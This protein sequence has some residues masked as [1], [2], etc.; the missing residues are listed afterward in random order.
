[1]EAGEGGAMG[2]GLGE[3]AVGVVGWEAGGVE[4]LG[5]SGVGEGVGRVGEGGIG[6]VG[7]GWFW[8]SSGGSMERW[9]WWASFMMTRR[10]MRWRSSR[11]L[12]GQW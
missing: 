11:T 2:S 10:S 9:I 12:P 6:V 8:V 7:S 5:D 4:I 1:M 3:V